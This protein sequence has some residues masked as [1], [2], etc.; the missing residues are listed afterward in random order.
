VDAKYELLKR[1]QYER[2][3]NPLALKM[4][5][6]TPLE[7]YEARNAIQIARAM[8]ADRFALETLQKAE[9]S[10]A[11]AEA[12][13]TRKAGRKPVTMMAREAVQTAEDARAIAV[14]RQAEETLALERQQSV[15][16]EARSE[17]ARVAAQLD[18]DRVTRDAEAARLAAAAEADRMKREK[19]AQAAA[20]SA[21][22]AGLKAETDARAAMPTPV[23]WQRGTKRIAS[24]RRTTRR[25][26]P[27]V[28]PSTR[29]LRRRRSWKPRRWSC[30][31]ACSHSSLRFCKRAIRPAG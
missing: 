21:E 23:R 13:Q 9:K 22:L 31:P 29:P 24:S 25:M 10:L 11:Q 20:S 7:L 16:R 4:D 17:N 3:T 12:Y 18:A 19:D 27:A 30:G 14:Q 8:G 1:G 15:D 5:P 26:R 28:P 6:K 2:L